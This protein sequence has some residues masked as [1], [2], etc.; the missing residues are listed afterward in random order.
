MNKLEEVEQVE[1]ELEIDYNA[2]F[3]LVYVPD[4]IYEEGETDDAL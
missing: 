2:A 3:D 1:K 4:V